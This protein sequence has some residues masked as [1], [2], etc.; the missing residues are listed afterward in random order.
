MYEI[1]SQGPQMKFYW[2]LPM[3][4]ICPDYPN[5]ALK[6]LDTRNTPQSQ[7]NWDGWSPGTQ[8]RSFLYRLSVAAFTLQWQSSYDRGHMDRKA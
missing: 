3:G 5:L 7:A 8:P 6:V 4:T 1:Q 2:D